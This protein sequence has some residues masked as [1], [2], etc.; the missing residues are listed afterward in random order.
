MQSKPRRPAG[1]LVIPAY[2]E[3]GR[4]PKTLQ[5]IAAYAH[6]HPTW[7]LE[8]IV[9]DDGSTDETSEVVH[10]T[11]Q[12]PFRLSLLQHPTNRGKGAA[13]RTGLSAARGS[14]VLILDADGSLPV[15][16]LDRFLPVLKDAPIVISSKYLAPSLDTA[17]QSW[18]RTIVS[19][20]G[21][22]LVRHLFGLPYADTQCGFKLLRAEAARAIAPYLTIPRWAFDIEL[23]VI[24]RELGLAV[25]E[26]P[27]AWT[28]TDD[29]RVSALPAAWTSVG[30][31]LIIWQQLK[32]GTYAPAHL[33][34]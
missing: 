11:R 2:N 9:V 1:S 3:A 25:R 27:I 17:R 31:L 12:L 20:T 30:E 5:E 22:W 23:L 32:R 15:G 7:S 24:A 8:V 4:L 21:N 28:N 10:A 6:R 16:E 18:D 14:W 29:S 33:T 26:L 34:R 19:R 13:V